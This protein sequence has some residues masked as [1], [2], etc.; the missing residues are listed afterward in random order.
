MRFVEPAI[1]PPLDREFRPAVL[2]HREFQ[3]GMEAVSE[4]GVIG[5]DRGNGNFSRVEIS[6]LPEGHSNY[7]FNLQYVVRVAKF[8]LWQRG[9]HTLYFGGPSDIGAY[10]RDTFSAGGSRQFDHQFMGDQVY[11]QEFRVLLCAPDEIPASCEEGKLLGREWSGCR[12][13]FDLGASDRKVSAVVDGEPVFSEEVVWEPRK[14]SDPEYFYRELIT[15]LKNAARYMPRLDAVGGSSAG[16]IVDNRPMVASLFRGVPAERFGEIKN[17]FLRIREEL[18]VPME[19]INDGDV[20]ALAGSMSIGESGILGLALGSSLAAGYVAPDGKI[21][22]WLNELAFAPID[23]NPNAPVE[24]W[25]GDQGCGASY[26]SQ[27]CVFRLA[28]DAGIDIPA[29]LPDADKLKYVQAMLEDGHA[30]AMKIWQTMGVYLGYG[31]ALYADY[32]DLKHVL[33]LGRCTSGRGG[34]LLLEGVR[35][36][37]EAEFPALLEKIEVHLPD[38]KFRRIG[39]SVAAA[40]L[41]AIERERI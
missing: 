30:G 6:L 38:E 25:S 33:I 9:G 41:P 10:L 22:G 8:L 11:E 15:A 1:L 29:A 20:T 21:T 31:I 2:T 12:I 17:L 14:H 27:Q 39:Q 32:Y 18:G 7:E 36:V 23:Y 34:D 4:P 19:V 16:I 26:F 35:R 28:P 5:L 13:G 37:F 3:R 40:S 24:E